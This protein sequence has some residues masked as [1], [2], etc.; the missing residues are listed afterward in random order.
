M[1]DLGFVSFSTIVQS[2]QDDERMIMTGCVQWHYVYDWKI[3][4]LRRNSNQGL[5]LLSYWGSY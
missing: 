4:R 1:D 2:Y 5:N 3:P